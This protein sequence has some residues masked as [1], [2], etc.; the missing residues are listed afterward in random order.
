M[1]NRCLNPK[2]KDFAKYGGTGVR[3]C[4]RWNPK[5][6]GSFQNFLA[7]MGEIPNGDFSLGR[8]GDGMLYGP[9]DAFYQSRRVQVA[10]RVIKRCL[11]P[12]ETIK[13]ARAYRNGKSLRVLAAEFGRSRSTIRKLLRILGVKLR[14]RGRS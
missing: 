8:V 3:V 5:A 2:V 6:G 13:L 7:D 9:G 10:T 14:R 12:T 4:A 1:L 11:T